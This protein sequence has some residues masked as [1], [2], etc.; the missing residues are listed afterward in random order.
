MKSVQNTEEFAKRA[1]AYVE[2]NH[3]VNEEK[4]KE[5]DILFNELYKNRKLL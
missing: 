1:K 4:I 5:I 3:V 2:K